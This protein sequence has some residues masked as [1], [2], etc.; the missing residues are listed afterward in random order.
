MCKRLYIRLANVEIV[1]KIR[2]RIRSPFNELASPSD[3]LWSECYADTIY[4]EFEEKFSV[5]Q[6]NL[7]IMYNSSFMGRGPMTINCS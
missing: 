6:E 3:I 4:W 1:I 7:S 5:L 2:N